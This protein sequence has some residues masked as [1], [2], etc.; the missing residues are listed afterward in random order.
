MI[1]IYIAVDGVF[2]QTLTSFKSPP[3]AYLFGRVVLSYMIQD[4]SF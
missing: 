4:K 3:S 2:A 1:N